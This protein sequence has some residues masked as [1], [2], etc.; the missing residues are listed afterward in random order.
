MCENDLREDFSA[1]KI[2][3][4]KFNFNIDV[5]HRLHG[6]QTRVLCSSLTHWT[7]E[8]DGQRGF[9]E[10]VENMV[11]VTLR[12]HVLKQISIPF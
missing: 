7:V 2:R 3:L 1:Q 10:A 11:N 5:T 12:Q 6:T 4:R 8:L 9:A